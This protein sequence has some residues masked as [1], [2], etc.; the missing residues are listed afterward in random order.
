MRGHRPVAQNNKRSLAVALVLALVLTLALVSV[1][2]TF[3]MK[4]E[5]YS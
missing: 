4:S 1:L 3:K 5:K 2:V